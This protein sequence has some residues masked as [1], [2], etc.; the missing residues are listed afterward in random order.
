MAELL[1]QLKPKQ[2][3]QDDILFLTGKKQLTLETS[4]PVFTCLESNNEIEIELDFNLGLNVLKLAGYTS[5]K[6]NDAEEV[7]TSN[8]EIMTM[9]FLENYEIL[10]YE[11]LIANCSKCEEKSKMEE[12]VNISFYSLFMEN[13][14]TDRSSQMLF[15]VKF[16]SCINDAVKQQKLFIS[17]DKYKLITMEDI[18]VLFDISQSRLSHITGDYF[19]KSDSSFRPS[20]LSVNQQWK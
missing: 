17:K 19:F 8:K 4:T 1:K 5:F 9:K 14:V 11:D 10:T 2:A 6:T 20:K 15:F 12:L 3:S 7:L 16:V 13:I 18:A